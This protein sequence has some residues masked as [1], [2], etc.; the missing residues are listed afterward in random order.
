MMGIPNPD[1]AGT[2]KQSYRPVSFMNANAKILS[3]ILAN[4][5]SLKE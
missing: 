3:K 2:E 4:P 5:L 1:K